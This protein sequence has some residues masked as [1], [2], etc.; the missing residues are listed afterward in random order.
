MKNIR[1]ILAGMFLIV[2]TVFNIQSF[3]RISPGTSLSNV[4]SQVSANAEGGGG[5]CTCYFYFSYG[6]NGTLICT[7]QY[8]CSYI[9]VMFA[10]WADECYET[11]GIPLC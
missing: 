4:I 8:S 7:S 3:D 6:Y 5:T 11:I 9:Y 2:L 1:I 10:D